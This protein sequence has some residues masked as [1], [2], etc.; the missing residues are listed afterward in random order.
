[1]SREDG[2]MLRVFHLEL[3]WPLHTPQHGQEHVALHSCMGQ[4]PSLLRDAPWQ[5]KST[6]TSPWGPIPK[7][8]A[9]V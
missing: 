7:A 5:Q 2:K 9:A 3:W 6:H 4:E 1:M 8:A